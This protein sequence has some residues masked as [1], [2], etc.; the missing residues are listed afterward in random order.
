MS[1]TAWLFFLP[2]CFALNMAPGPNNLLS[3]NVAARHG[4]LRA[5]VGGARTAGERGGGQR[6]PGQE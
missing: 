6:E 2:A 5:F 3:I 4:F 1:L